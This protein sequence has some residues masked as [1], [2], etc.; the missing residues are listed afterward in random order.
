MSIW[1]GSASGSAQAGARNCKSDVAS[2]LPQGL[3]ALA[4]NASRIASAVNSNYAANNQNPIPF[5]QRRNLRNR[6][7][8]QTTLH[9]H[10]PPK[11]RYNSG[12]QAGASAARE[13]RG[14]AHT[15]ASEK[16][17]HNNMGGN[18]WQTLP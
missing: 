17:S 9:Y 13:E 7:Q 1:K 6:L 8:I 12:V 3:V 18:K 15:P 16:A 2:E 5:R 10:N 4:A 14:P 11:I